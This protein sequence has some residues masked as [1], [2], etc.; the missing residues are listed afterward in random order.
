MLKRNIAVLLTAAMIAGM[1]VPAMGRETAGRAVSEQRTAAET[2]RE[3]PSEMVK[4]ET[5]EKATPSEVIPEETEEENERFMPE[6][7]AEEEDE[8]TE[9]TWGDVFWSF[10]RDTGVLTIEG[11]GRMPHFA[12][13][14]PTTAWHKFRNEIREVVIEEGVENLSD[15]SFSQGYDKV[16]KFSVAAS[17]TSI[18]SVAFNKVTDLPLLHTAGPAGGGYDYEFGWTERIPNNAFPHSIQELTLPDTIKWIGDGACGSCDLQEIQLPDGLAGIGESAFSYCEGL[19]SIDIP[20]SVTELGE[21]VL[22]GCRSLAEVHLPQNIREIPK[23]TFMFCDSLKTIDLPDSIERIGNSAFWGSGLEAIALPDGVT[24]IGDHAFYDTGIKS[25]SLPDSVTSIEADAFSDCEELDNV[26]L[27][28]GLTVIEVGVFDNC[29]SLSRIYIPE[30]VTSIE[31]AAFRDADRLTD[32]YYGGSEAE[33]SAVDISEPD[34]GN[35][36][37]LEATIHYNST[38]LFEERNYEVFLYGGY[39][40]ESGEVSFLDNESLLRYFVDDETDMSFVDSVSPG[41]KVIVYFENMGLDGSQMFDCRVISIVPFDM[42]FG[43]LDSIGEKT[44]VIDGTPY[45]VGRY[46]SG[47]EAGTDC[48]FYVQD[49]ILMYILP[50]SVHTGTLDSGTAEKAVISGTEYVLALDGPAPYLSAPELWLGHT[51]SFTDYGG[52]IYRLSLNAY[53]G[54]LTGKLT[55]LRQSPEGTVWITIDGE[56]TF[57]AAPGVAVDEL[58][59]GQWITCTV[60][61]TAEEG[62]SITAVQPVKA[63]GRAEIAM[64]REGDIYL[65]DDKYSFDGVNYDVSSKTEIGFTIT[66]KSEMPFVPEETLNEMREDSSLDL[67][68]KLTVTEPEGF[69]FGWTGT[70]EIQEEEFTLKAGESRELSGFVRPGTLYFVDSKLESVTETIHC[71]AAF[72]NGQTQETEASFTIV[73]QD[74]DPGDTGDEN[75]GEGGQD[76]DYDSDAAVDGVGETE[77][78]RG[79]LREF[80]KAKDID[81]TVTNGEYELANYFDQDVTE[82]IVKIVSVWTTAMTSDLADEVSGEFP[83]YLKLEYE[84]NGRNNGHKAAIFFEVPE[85]YF[86]SAYA[87][88]SRISYTLVDETTGR[89]LYSDR[90]FSFSA[91]ASPSA[92][93]DGVNEYLKKEYGD[94]AKKM[95]EKILKRSFTNIAHVTGSDYLE[96]VMTLINA[97]D[98]YGAVIGNAKKVLKNPVNV[99]FSL[100][101]DFNSSAKHV[102]IKCPVDVWVYDAGGELCG[103]IENNK[104]V[105]DSGRAFLYVNGDEKSVWLQ[106]GSFRLTATGEG[107]MD[108]SITEYENGEEGRTIMF[109]DVPLT[110]GIF[111][112]GKIPGGQGC[113]AADYVLISSSGES[114]FDDSAD[115]GEKPEEGGGSSSGGGGSSGGGSSSGGGGS[116][117]GGSSAAGPAVSGGPAGSSAN[118][119]VWVQDARGWWLLRSDGTW[120]KGNWVTDSQGNSGIAYEWAMVNGAW[121]VFDPYGYAAAGWVY[122]SAYDGWFYVDINSGMKDGWQ[123]I[124]GKWYYLN[125]ESDGTRGIMFSEKNT[126]DGYYVGKDGAWDGR[127]APAV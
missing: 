79:L 1:C 56:S 47:I 5:E 116:S 127:P 14:S 99:E 112:T 36:Q 102:S 100:V 62:T 113:P 39:D 109:S 68:V 73:N 48:M 92:F 76:D 71:T 18:S 3:T 2:A 45:P 15:Y 65:K 34:I 43:H 22:F 13:T 103:K 125:P 50:L 46:F 11:E 72:G 123:Q 6:L 118:Q 58:Q 24:S 94:D 74:Y 59:A 31:M 23:N 81:V 90:T 88:F 104:I 96:T 110:E 42:E 63:S 35:K 111:Y 16:E 52:V 41:Q 30:S 122:D 49:G 12:L 17:V 70:G 108:Y 38:G 67:T 7:L 33:W 93:A 54:T 32:V 107:T 85:S 82:D 19:S 57:Q 87:A 119:P 64:N 114:I 78:E 91:S 97:Y 120:P 126:P 4:E 124:D 8:E 89:T 75:P 80:Y 101:K 26:V 51:V 55:E 84:M 53:G 28:E 98:K 95:C 66:V 60:T 121:Y 10:D 115:S 37:L 21:R 20:D 61:T 40:P 44:A 86:E 105:S 25:I 77:W 69:N 27:P 9:G 106:E 83:R 29:S 117:G